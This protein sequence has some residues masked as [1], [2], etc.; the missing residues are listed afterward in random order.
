MFKHMMISTKLLFISSI[1]LI[2]LIVLSYVSINSSLV[3]QKSLE[4][5]Y[6]ENVVPD[7]DVNQARNSFDSILN[8]LIH[9]TSEFLP[10]GQAR[11]RLPLT[12]KTMDAFFAKALKEPFYQEVEI[13]K[14]LDEA[15]ARYQKKIVPSFATIHHLYIR[16]N[17]EDI[18]DIA[19]EV[20]ADSKYISQR[21][22]NI[23]K[24]TNQRVKNISLIISEKL[25]QNLYLVI[26]VS[27]TI[28][29]LTSSSLFVVSRYI[30]RKIR[31][32]GQHLEAISE[33]LA[34]NRPIEVSTMDEI[35]LMS[36]NIN[37]LISTLQQAILK[38]KTTMLTNATINQSMQSASTK[39]IHI[40]QEQDNIVETV[41]TLTDKIK[42]ELQE[43]R[44]VA[45]TSAEYMKQDFTMLDTMIDTLQNIV[46]SI[47]H[48]SSDEQTISTQ[49]HD[50]A[51]Q[52]AQIKSILEMIKEIAEQT[53]LLALNAAIEAARAGEHGRGF[54][55]VADEVRK[56]AERTQ[57]SLL[58]IDA[59]ISIVIQSVSN[60]SDNIK[61]NSEK[62][63]QLNQE[64]TRITALANE[65]K[66]KTSESLE[67]TTLVYE[68]ALHIS[69]QIDT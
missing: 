29:V 15:Y 45:Q 43:S 21:F 20:E 39:I 5:I 69:S 27:L 53:N 24:L 33:D 13:K 16:D 17:K 64:A 12:Q 34:L 38:A 59:T 58:E 22:D 3:G 4:T 49:M 65:T 67:I 14:N 52:T 48:V 8:D 46:R 32:I 60:A 35:G 61:N 28:L 54:A 41:K 31:G 26:A 68:K 2:G 55:V 50:L 23:S 44:D 6:H 30:V 51:E 7:M 1:T 9:V 40:A 36:K 10:T 63:M 47:N 25:H 56:L 57:K 19:V 42:Q 66:D 18:G 62:V 37:T 11:D